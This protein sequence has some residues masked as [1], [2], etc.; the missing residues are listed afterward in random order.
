MVVF[1]AVL[2]FF[3]AA[4]TE[5]LGLLA[6]TSGLGRLAGDLPSVMAATLVVLTGL[7]V[8][9]LVKSVVFQA[10]KSSNL[11]YG[12]GLANVAKGG[13]L[14]LAGVVALDQIG[15]DS[16]LL[17]LVTSIVIGVVLSGMALAFGLGARTVVGNIIASHYLNQ[18]YRPGQ[19]VRIG[20]AREKIE[21]IQPA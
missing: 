12:D 13:V 2:L 14:V 6:V 3:V 9:N 20:D 16:T 19:N 1:W 17:I 18:A 4:A 21:K 15:I 11:S 7:V 10:A 8:G 5:A